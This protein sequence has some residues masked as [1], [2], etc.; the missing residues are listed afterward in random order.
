MLPRG[1]QPSSPRAPRRRGAALVVALGLLSL[2]LLLALAF[3]ASMQ[4]ERLAA[5]NARS[6]AVGRQFSSIAPY[7]ASL[8]LG[9]TNFIPHV[10]WADEA[11]DEQTAP[12]TNDVIVRVYGE[13]N[14]TQRSAA[15]RGLLIG[16]DGTEIDGR[17]AIFFGPDGDAARFATLPAAATNFLPA[18]LSHVLETNALP[19]RWQY[20][21]SHNESIEGDYRLAG[22][23]TFLAA[24]LSGQA[25]VHR[26]S[27]AQWRMAGVAEDEVG[28]L[29]AAVTNAAPLAN[30]PDLLA[31]LR[32]RPFPL[33]DESVLDALGTASLDPDPR[34]LP[35]GARIGDADLLVTN[36]FDLASLTNNPSAVVRERL[37][38]ECPDA[39]ADPRRRWQEASDDDSA[40][41]DYLASVSNALFRVRPLFDGGSSLSNR[42]ARAVFW[43]LLNDLDADRYPQT[44]S[45]APWLDD[46]GVEALPLLSELALEEVGDIPGE[47]ADNSPDT[48]DAGPAPA[49]S[50]DG[51][52]DECPAC[53]RL[54]EA[55]LAV[56]SYRG[57]AELWYPFQ[58]A[59]DA[60][61][62]SAWL[63][64]HLYAVTYTNDAESVAARVRKNIDDLSAGNVTD[65]IETYWS[66]NVV[67]RP[68]RHAETTDLAVPPLSFQTL[69][70]GSLP[71]ANDDGIDYL[72]AGEVVVPAVPGPS[73]TNTVYLVV[74]HDIDSLVT[75]LVET[76]T[77]NLVGDIESVETNTVETVTT[78][79]SV[80]AAA[81]TVTTNAPPGHLYDALLGYD[82]GTGARAPSPLGSL[83]DGEYALHYFTSNIVEELV[84]DEPEAEDGDSEAEDGDPETG[85]GERETLWV[86]NTVYTSVFY[87]EPSALVTNSWEGER[88]TIL[89]N[90]VTTVTATNLFGDVSGTLTTAPS[91]P[92][93]RAILDALPAFLR[94]EEGSSQVVTNWND[95]TRY[96]V[97]VFRNVVRVGA[98]TR[99]GGGDLW[100]LLS[101]GGGA[102]SN[103]VARW[104]G[105]VTNFAGRADF[106]GRDERFAVS[107]APVFR[108]EVPFEHVFY[109]AD[110]ATVLESH[111]VSVPMPIGF[112]YRT[113]MVY[114]LT[115]TD[116]T[117][118]TD[119]T[120]S[121]AYHG[122]FWA[123]FHAEDFQEETVPLPVENTVLL[124]SQ[125][126]LEDPRLDTATGV[127][128]AGRSG[129]ARYPADEAPGPGSD[130]N[131][132]SRAG[133]GDDTEV[134]WLLELDRTLALAVDDPRFNGRTHRWRRTESD[135]LGAP[136][137]FLDG[138]LSSG[139]AGDAEEG[140]P[141]RSLSDLYPRFQGYPLL[142][143]DGL[144][145]R[146][147]DIGY[148]GTDEPWESLDL[149]APPGA[150]LLDLWCLAS[151]DGTN[152]PRRAF[153]RI[154]AQTP[155]PAAAAF[156]FADTAFGAR[157]LASG[158]A[159]ATFADLLGS[160]S[161][162]AEKL[163]RHLTNAVISA[164]R[165]FHPVSTNSLALSRLLFD[166]AGTASESQDPALAEATFPIA[167]WFGCL[168]PLLLE[169]EGADAPGPS[170]GDV[171]LEAL[172]SAFGVEPADLRA[173]FEGTAG[174]QAAAPYDMPGLDLFEDLFR[175]LPD[176]VTFRQNLVLVVACSEALA[177]N[178]RVE[179][180]TRTVYLLFR[181]AWTGAWNLVDELELR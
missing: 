46:Y 68:Y 124:S 6:R 34:Q 1:R 107:R 141:S 171:T 25:D 135:T 157:R 23:V 33:P 110:G 123:D 102:S 179:S 56:P 73:E 162:T 77:T 172:C 12:E 81:Y 167:Q 174:D 57:A 60:D 163:L 75:N 10:Y 125:V 89:S 88:T 127:P 112:G 72:A 139:S 133:A 26:L 142:H 109:D 146:I 66:T 24:D 17:E 83:L 29:L 92:A 85:D 74:R 82:P 7:V 44:D 53:R 3:V 42:T 22:R 21:T 100:T 181:D 121:A 106:D 14:A 175:D 78:N 158:D 166:D 8:F 169:T 132:V 45:D 91:T 131:L 140:A 151:P 144:P 97:E 118:T 101:S 103:A 160:G 87:F 13:G 143:H 39:S 49:A 9:S 84:F 71:S 27:P 170:S 136:P 154:H 90:V 2:V 134:P 36:K 98:E 69:E 161:D 156:L 41:R 149:L 114:L 180:A 145:A 120:G 61:I 168:V 147:G 5:R 153:G 32:R 173:A 94:T 67:R 47:D 4:T 108:F 105:C 138:A 117:D 16:S 19:L 62:P 31:F 148:L 178:G 51:L 65:I 76:V 119:G 164:A 18:A 116:G 86:T 152:A 130:T 30:R 20:I 28:P 48:A 113:N 96:E 104:V 52:V 40:V 137:D 99:Q 15:V 159:S 37:F 129:L 176:R 70:Y 38:D 55:G 93:T 126:F 150:K 95:A 43:N 64:Q 50:L 177:P 111:V 122:D 155:F 165:E 79:L 54:R 58:R 80:R 115:T 59:T 35:Y 63:A 11:D 128:D